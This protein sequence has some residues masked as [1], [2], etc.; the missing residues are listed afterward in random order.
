MAPLMILNNCKFKFALLLLSMFQIQTAMMTFH[1]I[2]MIEQMKRCSLTLFVSKDEKVLL[3]LFHL[4]ICSKSDEQAC[5]GAGRQC[6]RLSF[7]F[8][9]VPNHKSRCWRWLPWFN[10]SPP[11]YRNPIIK[12]GYYHV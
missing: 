6:H 2:M 8:K 5:S 10:S 7:S 3:T 9:F 12:N 1:T 4:Q 11:I